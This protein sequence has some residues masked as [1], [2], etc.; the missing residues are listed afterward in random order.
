MLAVTPIY[1]VSIVAICRGE[2]AYLVE[3]VNYH[4]Q[5][6]VAHFFIYDN[7]PAGSHADLLRPYADLVTYT[8]WS[9][10]VVSR[11]RDSL[12]SARWTCASVSAP[13]LT[14]AAGPR[15]LSV[16]LGSGT[17]SPRT[18][19]KSACRGASRPGWGGVG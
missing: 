16:K 19:G 7:E 14:S 10:V 2:Q 15:I 8:F 5:V 4:R 18:G 9:D 1:D 13:A 3:W 17:T 6:G 12:T 11:Y